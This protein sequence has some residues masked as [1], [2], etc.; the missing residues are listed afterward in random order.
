MKVTK[1]GAV[2]LPLVVTLVLLG[3]PPALF[4]DPIIVSQPATDYTF[5]GVTTINYQSFVTGNKDVLLKTFAFVLSGHY[6]AGGDAESFT[7]ND[8]DG[9]PMT[10][11]TFN[12]VNP[13]SGPYSGKSLLEGSFGSGIALGWGTQYSLTGDNSLPSPVSMFGSKSVLPYFNGQVADA[14]GPEG[15]WGT[16]ATFFATGDPLGPVSVPEPSS[17]TLVLLGGLVVG[18]CAW[19][20]MHLAA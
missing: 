20:K 6:V 15:G 19:R 3:L 18:G 7:L 14:A 13:N 17:M 4:A 12:I 8:W 16:G 9:S 10:T 1:I 11:T 5:T 2:S